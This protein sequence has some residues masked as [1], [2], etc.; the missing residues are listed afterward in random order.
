M[1]HQHILQ[2]GPDRRILRYA[3]HKPFTVKFPDKWQWQNRMKLGITEGLIWYTHR[4]KTNKGT[5]AKMYIWGLRRG[6]SFSPG[7]HTTVYQAEVCVIKA[8]TT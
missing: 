8:C 4:S 3:Y 1:E 6:H 7:L 2:M 5:G